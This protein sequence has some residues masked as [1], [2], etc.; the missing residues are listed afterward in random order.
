MSEN[1]P[2]RNE[3]LPIEER[4]DDLMEKLTL[5]EKIKL[6][7]GKMIFWTNSIK[8]LGIPSMK[9]TDGPHG[10]GS[11][12]FY[13]KKMT[14]YPVAICRTATWNK[15]LSYKFG[16]AIADEARTV[17]RHMVLAPGINIIRTPLCGRNFEYQTE[18]PFLN[19]K[20]A[21]ELIKGVQ[22][23]HVSTCVKHF[24]ANNQEY[25]RFMISSEVSERALQEIYLPAFK[26]SIEEADAWSFMACY[27]KVN[28]IY[29]CENSQLIREMLMKT[30]G[31]K[32]FV[33]SDWLA[34]RNTKT[35]SSIRAGLSLEMPFAI[36]YKK[37][38]IKQALEKDKILIELFNDNIRRYLRVAFLVGMFD[39]SEKPPTKYRNIIEHQAL[40]LKIAEEGIVLL[41]NQDNILPLNINT[42]RKIALIGPNLNKKHSMAGGSSMVRTKYE[43][44]PKKGMK[45][46][47]KEKKIKI[48]KSLSKAD[49]VIIFAGLNHDKFM[50]RENKD[51]I[52]LEL[53]KK[54]LI[55]INE[56][57]K[58]NKNTIIVLIGGSPIGMNGWIEN[59]PGILMMWYAGMEG[60][61]AIANILFGDVNPSGKLP[62]TFPITL[63][64]SPAHKSYRTYPGLKDWNSIQE[65]DIEIMKK[66]RGVIIKSDNR[67]KVFYE[68]DIF[69]GYRYFDTFQIEPLFPFGHGLSYTTFRFSNLVI[70]KHQISGDE[71]IKVE[72][73]MQN[74][75]NRAGAEVVQLYIQDLECS[76][77][78]PLK[79]LKAF[80]KIY[81]E[82]GEKK[83]ITFDIEKKH[84]AFFCEDS[85]EW[86]VENGEFAILIGNSSTNIL[87]QGK[88]RYSE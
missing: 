85:N 20:I 73:D 25:N 59:V 23:N 30:W 57:I 29:G 62:V 22:S 38:L 33:V 39:N 46:K 32:G 79:E 86:K 83:K 54:Q 56:C 10:I 19:S 14:Y 34:T 4:L 55:L 45:L 64:D 48:T 3:D 67:D 72:L 52:T 41:K 65:G 28:G 44:I 88:F 58:R 40:S 75:G 53:P 76:V 18:D 15:D 81:L 11:G 1:I 51:R 31:F 66:N 84:L 16:E 2:F 37:K 27:N 35:N 24:A 42:I 8:R 26:A 71:K 68:E 9:L 63:K 78:R 60:G 7:H 70:D 77:K 12:I 61:N 49:A 47:C 69:V 5:N 21:V 13:L 36:C 50:D 74:T 6:C 43:I 80:E 87:L 82:A 17:G